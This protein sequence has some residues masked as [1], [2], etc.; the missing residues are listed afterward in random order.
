[1]QQPKAVE[2]IIIIMYYG[3]C[4]FSILIFICRSVSVTVVGIYGRESSQ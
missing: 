2:G 3:D 4:R 1:M